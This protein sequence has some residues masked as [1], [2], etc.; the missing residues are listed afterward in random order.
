MYPG[1][2]TTEHSKDVGV[3][4]W[5]CC[6]LDLYLFFYLSALVS[7]WLA[8]GGTLSPVGKYFLEDDLADLGQKDLGS[9]SKDTS[10]VMQ[11][12]LQ[13]GCAVLVG[14]RIVN[15]MLVGHGRAS[16]LVP[17]GKI[18]LFSP[19]LPAISGKM[20][21]LLLKSLASLTCRHQRVMVMATL[22]QIL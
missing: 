2:P 19:V 5:F 13:K 14:K 17:T 20:C 7:C 16:Y 21:A 10:K 1:V 4:K 15:R 8:E 6:V 11:C 3:E 9:C 22:N 18:G 12:F